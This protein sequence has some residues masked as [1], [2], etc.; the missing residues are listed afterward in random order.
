MSA[1]KYFTMIACLMFMPTCTSA[2][3]KPWERAWRATARLQ[4]RCERERER[5]R[6]KLN[7]L[8]A[9]AA[10]YFLKPSMVHGSYETITRDSCKASCE[11]QRMYGLAWPLVHSRDFLASSW[12]NCETY[13]MAGVT[14]VT[15]VVQLDELIYLMHV[16]VDFSDAFCYS[17]RL[18]PGWC[19]I[20]LVNSKDVC[21]SPVSM[22]FCPGLLVLYTR[23][24]Q[25]TFAQ[26]TSY[27]SSHNVC[28]N[29]IYT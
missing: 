16:C 14:M 25:Q 10:T 24:P 23:P 1:F 15:I 3:P 2:K 19:S 13:P 28:H 4:V 11:W 12:F 26:M 18:A 22:Q 29:S 21:L 5:R 17:L 27:I 6:L 7:V 20:F 9:H 8:A